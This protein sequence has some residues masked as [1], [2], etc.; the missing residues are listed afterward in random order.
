MGGTRGNSPRRPGEWTVS[1]L[2]RWKNFSPTPSLVTSEG[3]KCGKRFAK[4]AKFSRTV[5]PKGT[6]RKK[7]VSI[8]EKR[9][10]PFPAQPNERSHPMNFVVALKAEATPLVESFELA[11]E[12]APRPSQSLQTIGTDS[13]SPEWARSLRPKPRTS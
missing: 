12:N 7:P 10:V 13:F 1:A 11:K 4:N 5:S 2:S 9:K 3:M 6:N 8:P